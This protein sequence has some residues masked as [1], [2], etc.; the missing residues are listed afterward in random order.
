MAEWLHGNEV[1]TILGPLSWDD[2]GAP[3]GDFLLAQWQNGEVEIVAP[4]DAST[5][6]SAVAKTPWQG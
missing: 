3:Q 5:V 4:K 2:T 6:D 1:Q